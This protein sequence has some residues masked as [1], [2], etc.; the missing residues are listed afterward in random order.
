MAKKTIEIK[1]VMSEVLYDIQN[2][3]WLIGRSRGGGDAV[4]T[5]HMQ[6]DLEEESNRNQVLRSVS[7]AVEVLRGSMRE[8]LYN[9]DVV[10]D[11]VLIEAD[12]DITFTLLMPMNFSEDAVSSI[13]A[14]CHRYVVNSA[15]RDWLL[16]VSAGDAESYGTQASGDLTSLTILLH[17]RVR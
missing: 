12:K 14:L 7:N 4:G 15:L 8:Y 17:S 5:S 2:T 6:I 10:R 3:V 16:I 11:N 13:A 1:L 9:R